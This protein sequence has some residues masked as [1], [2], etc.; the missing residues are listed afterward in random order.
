MHHH[1]TVSAFSLANRTALVVAIALVTSLVAAAS[2]NAVSTYSLITKGTANYTDDALVLQDGSGILFNSQEQL[3]PEDTDSFYDVYANKGG[4]V[5]LVSTIDVAVPLLVEGANDDGSK[6]FIRTTGQLDPINDTDLAGQ[7]IYEL[8]GGTAKLIS[9]YDQPS[10]DNTNATMTFEGTSSDGTKVFYSTQAQQS[11]TDLDGGAVDIYERDTIANTTA[12]ISTNS[13]EDVNEG[14]DAEYC[15]ASDSGAVVAFTTTE[16]VLASDTDLGQEDAYSRSGGN[17]LLVSTGPEGPGVLGSSKCKDVS[18]DGTTI[19][20]ESQARLFDTDD[21]SNKWDVFTRSGNSTR[22]VSTSALNP[23]TAFDARYGDMSADGL[24]VY[25]NTAEQLVAGD[26]GVDVNDLDGYS[27]RPGPILT[28]ETGGSLSSAEVGA[29]VVEVNREATVDLFTSNDK[30]VAGDIDLEDSDLYAHLPE[31]GLI[32]VSTGPADLDTSD[33]MDRLFAN[34]PNHRWTM[35]ADGRLIG[36][37]TFARLVPEDTDSQMDVYAFQEKAPAATPPAAPAPSDTTA[38][39][40]TS[41]KLSNKTFAIDKNVKALSAAKTKKGT[42]ISFSLSET[43]SVKLAFQSLTSGRKSGSK[44]VKQTAK[45]KSAKS[46]TIARTTA[47][48]KLTGTAGSNSKSFGGKIGS[49]TLKPGKYQL[50][51]SATDSAGNAS[52]AKPV[53]FTIVK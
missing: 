3:V 5:S 43:A 24:A 42:K 37:S 39:S 18:H 49:K 53:K 12:Q 7:D 11:A 35:S 40:I 27:S 21:I 22:W 25:F 31:T 14:E 41:T 47:T 36:F 19:A 32:Q 15:G 2:A 10:P 46:C 13:T 34:E 1:L 29:Q 23:A 9:R 28:L 45:N 20:F 26:T 16:T 50:V 6:V 44:C 4:V 8:S 33:S 48:A 30:Y 17:T 51:I 38:P 52:S